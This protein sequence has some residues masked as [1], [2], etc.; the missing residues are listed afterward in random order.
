MSNEEKNV[1]A[2]QYESFVQKGLRKCTA[3][4]L[5]PLGALITVGFL[6]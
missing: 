3:E 1:E 6:T 5:V 4:P 2:K